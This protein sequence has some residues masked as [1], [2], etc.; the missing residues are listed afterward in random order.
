MH[1]Y[2]HAYIHTNQAVAFA[3]ELEAALLS[4]ESFSDSESARIYIYIYIY[5]YIERERA[6]TYT[7]MH[8]YIHANQA[9][10]FADELEAALLSCE[11]FSD[12]ESARQHS[13]NVENNETRS[14][15]RAAL[16]R[17]RIK[18]PFM[19]ESQLTRET[20]L[21]SHEGILSACVAY[22]RVLQRRIGSVID[23]LDGLC[24]RGIVSVC[25]SV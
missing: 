1:T 4:C 9:V 11:S 25:L 10:A 21:Y 12:S 6:V 24:Q 2:I 23:M 5:I 3:D 13:S 8:A 14:V 19:G 7:C 17:L 16:L 22:A 15:L 20:L 18:N